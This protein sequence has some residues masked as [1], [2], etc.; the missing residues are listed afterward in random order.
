MP[1]KETVLIID[2]DQNLRETLA[3]ILRRAGYFVLSATDVG[4]GF[5]SL[6]GLPC[7]LVIFDFNN[8]E[9]CLTASINEIHS[10]RPDLPI[11]VMTSSLVTDLFKLSEEHQVRGYLEKP[12]DP[13]NILNYIADLMLTT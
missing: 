5:N 1:S 6:H 4:R 10:F 13:G 7:D 9:K 11:V 3:L 2:D 12:V 8:H